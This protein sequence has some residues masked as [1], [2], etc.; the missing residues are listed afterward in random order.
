[1]VKH[2]N[3]TGTG[4]S[5]DE[6]VGNTPLLKLPRP[7]DISSDVELFGKAEWFNP[8][9][10][11]KDRPALRM[12]VAAEQDGTL[13]RDRTLLDATSGNTGI[14]YA[15]IGAARG[16]RVELTIPAN[17]SEERK[18][19]LAAYGATVHWTSP[20]EASDG[21]IRRAHALYG[22]NPDRYV[23]L[24]QYNNPN[25]PLAHYETTGPEIWRQTHG[26][27]THFVAGLGTSGTIMGCGRFL[28]ETRPDIKICAVEPATPL[29]GLEGLKHMAT[30]IV[31][32]I[33][34]SRFPDRIVPV[35]TE[36]AY[37]QARFLA[38]HGILV[39][40][41][42]GAAYAAAT[43]IARELRRGMIV[44]LLPDA[45]DRYLSTVL[46]NL[47]EIANDPPEG[48]SYEEAG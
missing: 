46:Y 13:T 27:V 34:D 5:I 12:V 42:A 29:H 9:G 8:G 25:N 43:Q 10:S 15:M 3:G 31:P 22:A 2:E 39:G 6:L 41:S 36:D 40:M 38:R 48:W 17:V 47:E 45:G 20:L 11:V 28:R 18:R 33:Y 16:Y 32:G 14:A 24:D 35:F 30:S 7:T 37:A 1:M 23:M 21:A 26:R 4:Q 44:V 19:I